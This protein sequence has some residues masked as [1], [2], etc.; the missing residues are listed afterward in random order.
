MLDIINEVLDLSKIEAGQMEIVESQFDLDELLSCVERMFRLKAEQ[1]DL[2]LRFDV[3]TNTSSHLVGDKGKLRQVLVNLIGNAVKFTSQGGIEVVVRG[4]S[5]EYT[6]YD[7]R[8]VVLAFEIIDTGP[9]I[10]P[11]RNAKSLQG[12]WTNEIGTPV[13]HW[14]RTRSSHLKETCGIDGGKDRSLK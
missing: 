14:N 3:E 9:G 1:K 13:S 7:K 12:V 5:R 10:D 2:Y 11:S 4:E 8:E 6:D